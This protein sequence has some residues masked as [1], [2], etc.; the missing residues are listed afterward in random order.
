MK[1]IA[2]FLILALLALPVVAATTGDPLDSN[3]GTY[4]V[5]GTVESDCAMASKYPQCV[6]C[7]TTCI[8]SIMADAWGSD[9]WNWDW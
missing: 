5:T 8:F 2:S 7:W 9:D 4:V 3:D 6:P 1:L